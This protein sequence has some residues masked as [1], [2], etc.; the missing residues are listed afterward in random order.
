[1]GNTTVTKILLLRDF[2]ASAD[3]DAACTTPE[4][5]LSAAARAFVLLSPSVCWRYSAMAVRNGFGS[6]QSTMSMERLISELSSSNCWTD[7][8]ESISEEDSDIG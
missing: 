7:F 1:M 6:V 4:T 8:I 5:A 3:A 2:D